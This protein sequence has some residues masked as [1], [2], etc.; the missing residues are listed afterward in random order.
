MFPSWTM[1]SIGNSDDNPASLLGLVKSPRT[2]PSSLMVRM[3][4]VGDHQRDSRIVKGRLDHEVPVRFRAQTR[5]S[6]LFPFFLRV[7]W[8]SAALLFVQYTYI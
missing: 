2:R 3:R 5:F 7:N 6:F 1:C 8:N 4:G